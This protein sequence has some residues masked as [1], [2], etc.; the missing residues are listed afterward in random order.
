MPARKSTPYPLLVVGK[1]GINGKGCYAAVRFGPRR[2][3]GELTGE[4]ISNREAARRVAQGG[5]VHICQLDDRW[6][7]DASRSAN[8]T[9]YIN[10]SCAPNCFSRITHGHMLFFA[11]REIRAGEE[12]TLDY[13]PSQHP[14]RRCTCGAA[15]CRGVMA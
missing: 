3:V 11:L 8:P 9:T 2:K 10:H 13:T 12:L 5:K 6:S 15:T 7:V 4:K 14:G 1:S